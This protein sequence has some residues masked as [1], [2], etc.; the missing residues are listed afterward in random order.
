MNY[1]LVLGREPKISLAEIEALFSSSKV[2]QIAPNLTKKC[3]FGKKD[4][5]F[6]VS[7]VIHYHRQ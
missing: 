3:T 7:V 5:R 6:V 2:K 1:L 4:P